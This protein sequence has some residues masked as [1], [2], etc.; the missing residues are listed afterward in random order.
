MVL[1]PLPRGGFKSFRS[2]RRTDAS[3]SGATA[4]PS[5]PIP[6]LTVGPGI[7]PESTPGWRPGGRRL[8]FRRWGL[9]PR[10]EDELLRVLLGRVYRQVPTAFRGGALRPAAVQGVG[11]AGVALG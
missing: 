7:S 9:A 11:R 2:R 6:T 5:T 3:M 10:P 4:G 8:L 1:T